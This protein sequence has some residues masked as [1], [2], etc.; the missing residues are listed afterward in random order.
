MDAKKLNKIPNE[1]DK[2][3]EK[4]ALNN[5]CDNDEEEYYFNDADLR[6]LK[7]DVSRVAIPKK[8]LAEKIEEEL[9][10]NLGDT[11]YCLG[12]ESALKIL[13]RELLASEDKNEPTNT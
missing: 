3:I 13:R 12:Y 6:V 11:D 10:N 1:I 4:W 8:V 5:V 7:N 2:A 9:T